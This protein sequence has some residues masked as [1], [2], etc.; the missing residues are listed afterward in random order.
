MPSTTSDGPDQSQKVILICL[1][2]GRPVP[3]HPSHLPT[4][5]QHVHY[6]EAGLEAE[7]VLKPKL[8]DMGCR[9]LKHRAKHLPLGPQFCGSRK[10]HSTFLKIKRCK[11]S[12]NLALR[13]AVEIAGE[14]VALTVSSACRDS[15][16][17]GAGVGVLFSQP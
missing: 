10:G 12:I 17:I 2:C 16:R 8:S 5:F 3:K 13:Q 11:T 6:K 1:L 9:W 14:V 15:A 7:Q 4:A